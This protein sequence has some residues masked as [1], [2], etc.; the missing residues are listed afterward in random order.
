MTIPPDNMARRRL[1]KRTFSASTLALV[2]ASGLLAPQRVLAHW[3]NEAFDAQTVEDA[4]LALMGQTETMSSDDVTFSPGKPASRIVSG[5]VVTVEVA[6]KLADLQQMMILVDNNPFP[7]VMSLDLTAEVKLPFKT[8]IE[9]A[10]D[11]QIIAVVRAG[12]KLYAT[13]R[14]VTVDVG[15]QP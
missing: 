1:L 5:D 4:L 8:R 6:S 7:L 13:Q 9:V 10:Q 11:S 14:A 12:E 3:P 15:G 2:A